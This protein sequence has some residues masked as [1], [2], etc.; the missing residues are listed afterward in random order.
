MKT[1]KEEKYERKG[2]VKK[3]WEEKVRDC[4]KPFWVALKNIPRL[5]GSRQ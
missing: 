4:F 3:R 1:I 2:Q 5:G